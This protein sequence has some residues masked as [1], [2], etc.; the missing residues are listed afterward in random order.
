MLLLL[1]LPLVGPV[2]RSLAG[3]AGYG[4]DAYRALFATGGR[5]GPFVPPVEAIGNSLAFAVLVGVLATALGVL[6][7]TGGARRRGRSV[8]VSSG[9]STS[10]HWT[11]A[12]PRCPSPWPTPWWRCPSWSVPRFRS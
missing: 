11:C 9:R 5:S 8:S 10:H 12:R 4:L 7:A 1:V 3:D 2:E 6:G